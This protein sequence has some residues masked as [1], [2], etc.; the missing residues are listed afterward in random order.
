MKGYIVL[1]HDDN[2]TYSQFRPITEWCWQQIGWQPIT[3]VPPQNIG[4]RSA[5]YAQMMRLWG[6]QQVV[7]FDPKGIVM[8]GD[9]DMIPLSDYWHPKSDEVTIY[10]HDLTVRG[11]VPICYIAMSAEKWAEV[12]HPTIGKAIQ[13][14][15]KLHS[16]KWEEWWQVDQDYITE[17]LQAYGYDRCTF[18][19]R[20]LER[21]GRPLGRV[22]RFRW[23]N[24]VT[25]KI[26]SHMLRPLTDGNNFERVYNLIES[27]FGTSAAWMKDYY[28]RI[29]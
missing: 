4:I 29:K 16:D 15:P 17:R 19:D 14:L 8:T 28:N 7:H 11:H 5:S 24:P 3:L 22:D 23:N 25:C 2:K 20:G 26:D 1:S 18:V 6:W 21:T 12:V 27:T 9:I 13:T 10:G